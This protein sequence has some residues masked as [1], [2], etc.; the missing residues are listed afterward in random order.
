MRIVFATITAA[1]LLTSA[2]Q[3]QKKE[4]P[5][6]P[7]DKQKLEA[8]QRAADEKDT[9]ERYRATLKQIPDQKPADPWAG[10]RAPGGGAK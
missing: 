5:Q 9:D 8:V 1:L 2:A 4:A 10:V 3:A 7:T 6:G